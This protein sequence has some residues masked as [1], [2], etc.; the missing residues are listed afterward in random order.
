MLWVDEEIYLCFL[1][2]M[3]VYIC[4]YVYI[5]IYLHICLH[6]YTVYNDNLK[7]SHNLKVESY[8]LFG[9][10]LGLQTLE[11]EMATH[12]SISA[13]RIP[14]TAEP[15]ELQSMGSKELYTTERLH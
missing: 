15:G 2:I 7:N 9:E 11:K 12:S 3:K 14:W 10:Y 4:V 6:M 1:N 8:V 5:N 13:W